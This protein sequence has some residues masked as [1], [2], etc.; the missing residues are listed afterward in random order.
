MRL[1]GQ[2]PPLPASSLAASSLA[3]VAWPPGGLLRGREGAALVPGSHSPLHLSPS[4]LGNHSGLP[5][6]R[7]LLSQAPKTGLSCKMV[8]QAVG[9]VLR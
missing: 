8:L 5:A 4:M 6:D 2:S 9:K 7:A 1:P 3:A